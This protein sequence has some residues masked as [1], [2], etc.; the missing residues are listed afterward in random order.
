[1]DGAEVVGWIGGLREEG[2]RG[3][4]GRLTLSLCFRASAAGVGFRRSSARTWRGGRLVGGGL[5]K[6]WSS[7]RAEAYH[8]G[9][10]ACIDGLCCVLLLSGGGLC[11]A[12]DG[13]VEETV[14]VVNESMK[15]C[16]E[17]GPL[18]CERKGLA[19]R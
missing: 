11:R 10:L 17:I 19:R 13:W 3:R 9:G 6:S 1:M 4:R 16:R 12:F 2:F 15:S 18:S 7:L 5:V 14:V 8:F